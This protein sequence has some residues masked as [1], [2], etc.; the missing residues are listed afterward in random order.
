MKDGLPAYTH[1]L[2]MSL[3]YN[4]L[5]NGSSTPAYVFPATSADNSA[6]SNTGSIPEG[7]LM[8][9]PPDFDSSKIVNADLKKVV[10]T[11]KL[12]GAYVVDRNTGTPFVI[13]AENDAGFNLM[14]KG[15]DNTVASQL[16][17]I[18]AALRQV[19]SAPG[20][21]DG[22]G[23]SAVDAIKAQQTMNMLSMRGPWSK[24]SGTA[25][26][27]YDTY[28]QSLLFSATTT[29]TV[30]SN[31]N[32]NGLTPVK[33]AMPKPGAYVKFTVSAT[34]GAKLRLQVY[35]GSTVNYDTWDMANGQSVRILWPVGAWIA[36]TATSGTSG[37]SSVKAELIPSP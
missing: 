15:W 5:S 35:S 1:A 14:P 23:D 13:Y 25:T 18:R 3:T 37:A 10:E 2:A 36:V 11:L 30:F 21:V 24:Q 17:Q 6:S 22:N 27:S 33:W 7:A 31:A 28:S 29:K 32:S 19:V 16:D 12:Y 9:L 34:G 26:A 4:A 20:W 8:M